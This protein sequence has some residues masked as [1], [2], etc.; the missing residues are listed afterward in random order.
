[1]EKK[2]PTPVLLWTLHRANFC[3]S[4][5]SGCG[6]KYMQALLTNS[7]ERRN[8]RRR[9]FQFPSRGLILLGH[10]VGVIVHEFLLME[11]MNSTR[12]ESSIAR[13]DPIQSPIDLIISAFRVSVLGLARA[14]VFFQVD[15]R[16]SSY[17]QFRRQ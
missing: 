13:P 2:F 8:I 6:L 4:I 7:R 10:T 14:A 17:L 5:I 15:R 9:L 3:F 11:E 12:F 16:A 1:M